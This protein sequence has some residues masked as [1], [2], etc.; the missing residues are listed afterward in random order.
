MKPKLKSMLAFMAV[1][2]IIF[3]GCKKS[4][5]L[6]SPSALSATAVKANETLSKRGNFDKHDPVTIT[7]DYTGRSTA[8]FTGSFTVTGV[9]AMEGTALMAVKTVGM[10][11]HC[12]NTLEL[13]G[14]TITILSVCQMADNTGIWYVEKGTGLYKKIQGDGTLIMTFPGSGIIVREVF[15]GKFYKGHD[16]EKE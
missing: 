15:I 6:V 1:S 13:P 8:G 11:F 7:F 2:F 10:E 12:I 9:P 3:T 16:H 14:G 4:D 5:S